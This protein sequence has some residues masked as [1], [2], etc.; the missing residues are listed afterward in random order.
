MYLQQHCDSNQHRK[1]ATKVIKMA[2]VVESRGF[3]PSVSTT[4]QQT[5][6]L[7]HNMLLMGY[8]LINQTVYTTS[9]ISSSHRILL[10]TMT[11]YNM[12]CLRQQPTQAQPASSST[13]P[14]L[15]VLITAL[16][17]SFMLQIQ[18]SKTLKS[19]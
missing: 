13:Y 11:V 19:S 18:W 6:G 15:I 2:A 14:S 1:H 9:W 4:E 16:G 7:Q 12:V 8:L 3:F 10:I 17:N 5:L